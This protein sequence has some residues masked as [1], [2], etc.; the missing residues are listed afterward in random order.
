MS[1]FIE[2]SHRDCGCAGGGDRRGVES[3]TDIA[4]AALR[5]K[6]RECFRNLEVAVKLSAQTVP[7][8]GWPS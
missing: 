8:R 1:R 5:C 4:R 6:T 3:V 7:K 2:A